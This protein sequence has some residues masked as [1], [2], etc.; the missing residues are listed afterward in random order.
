MMKKTRITEIVIE[1]T[2]ESITGILSLAAPCFCKRCGLE[3]EA[4]APVNS[5]KRVAILAVEVTEDR[6][7][8]KTPIG[9]AACAP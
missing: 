1:T 7:E 6:A 2:E 5:N 9:N 3:M 4:I 8:E